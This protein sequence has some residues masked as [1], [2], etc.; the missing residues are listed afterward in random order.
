MK[1]RIKAILAQASM[2]ANSNGISGADVLES[3]FANLGLAGLLSDNVMNTPFHLTG[4]KTEPISNDC[5]FFDPEQIIKF[6]D[7]DSESKSA[8][9]DLNIFDLGFN[10]KLSDSGQSSEEGYLNRKSPG[11]ESPNHDF[12]CSLSSSSDS[13]CRSHSFSV[14]EDSGIHSLHSKASNITVSK[15]KEHNRQMDKLQNICENANND[16]DEDDDNLSDDDDDDGVDDDCDTSDDASDIPSDT[17]SLADLDL[18]ENFLL[19]E[20]NDQQVI[21]DKFIQILEKDGSVVR[22][23]IDYGIYC[24]VN[25]SRTLFIE[26][27]DVLKPMANHEYEQYNLFPSRTEENPD[28]GQLSTKGRLILA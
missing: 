21:V 2:Q 8:L 7:S 18:D 19:D 15:L 27:H 3:S 23:K 10:D 17:E 14:E 25:E 12:S 9:T 24:S 5:S 13:G 28:S 11:S 22:K 20:C 4:T 26:P 16:D 1:A 6:C